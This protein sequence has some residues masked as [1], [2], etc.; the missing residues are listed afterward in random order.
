MCLSVS[1]HTD[2]GEE[3]L[4]WQRGVLEHL[5]LSFFWLHGWSMISFLGK[6]CP[7]G[8]SGGMVWV[9]KLRIE[10]SCGGTNHLNAMEQTWPTEMLFFH[11]VQSCSVPQFET[12]CHDG[13]AIFSPLISSCCITKSSQSL[14][15]HYTTMQVL[16][17]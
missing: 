2:E 3:C 7:V 17:L 10:A 9:R 15:L 16:Y 8:R 6:P 4:G 1:A 5:G 13:G 14:P 11:V 12:R